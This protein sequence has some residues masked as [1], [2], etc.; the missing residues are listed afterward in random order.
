MRGVY[1]HAWAKPQLS[2]DFRK[3]SSAFSQPQFR[4]SIF[5]TIFFLK[6]PF[7][8][9]FREYIICSELK[10]PTHC[11]EVLRTMN[12][13]SFGQSLD[14]IGSLEGWVGG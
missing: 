3:F 9:S 11:S 7:A 8:H 10:P 5:S 2:C 12:N 4:L 13:D 14:T 1:R 6:P